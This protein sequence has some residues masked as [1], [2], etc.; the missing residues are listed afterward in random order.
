MYVD[1][2]GPDDG[3]PIVFLHGSVVAG[4]M[5]MGQVQDLSEFRC[6]LPDLPGIRLLPVSG[7]PG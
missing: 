7:E 5:W 2:H 3:V 4:W 1:E 6:L